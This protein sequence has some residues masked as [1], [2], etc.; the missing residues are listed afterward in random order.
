MNR[1]QLVETVRKL[2]FDTEV[3]YLWEDPDLEFYY[4][5]AVREMCRRT[6]M[7][8]ETFPAIQSTANQYLYDYPS[9]LVL[10]LEITYDGD[11]L[12]KI[13]YERIKTVKGTT[14]TVK[15]YCLDYDPKK[16]LLHM[17]PSED[18]KEIVVYGASVP[19]DD[20]LQTA[21]PD[22][23]TDYLV[24]GMMMFAFQKTD[25]ETL[26]PYA[27]KYEALWNAYIEKINRDLDRNKYVP[28]SMTYVPRGLL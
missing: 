7:Y 17:T 4:A 1:S 22:H 3:P 16:I 26:S 27:Q 23:Y 15:Y 11:L 21:I 10:P 9:R 8:R 5:L 13:D 25:S 24:Y 18:G 6:L 2:L 28:V 19:D 14:G 12:T 20:H